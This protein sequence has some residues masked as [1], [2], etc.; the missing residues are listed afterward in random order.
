MTLSDS[1][2]LKYGE[3]HVCVH[4]IEGQPLGDIVGKY[5]GCFFDGSFDGFIQSVKDTVTDN[6]SR[7]GRSGERLRVAYVP[8]GNCHP[9]HFFPFSRQ[10]NQT[11]LGGLTG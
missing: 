3:N 9:R 7:F 11:Y 5:G 10:R 6:F 8:A 2:L 4:E 1:T